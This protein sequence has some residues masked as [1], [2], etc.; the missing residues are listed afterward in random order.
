VARD[1]YSEWLGIEGGPRPPDHYALLGI[2]RFCD[3]P[4]LIDTVA[5]QRLDL[6]DKYSLAGSREN[7][8]ACQEIMNEV[9]RARV[10]LM[11]AERRSLYNLQLG[12]QADSEEPRHADTQA[13]SPE[14][15]DFY[16]EIVWAH[17]RKWR[18]DVHEER[19]L[20]AEAAALGI[21]DHIALTIARRI[22]SQAEDLAHTKQMRTAFGAIFVACGILV[23]VVMV[24]VFPP[25]EDR[26]PSEGTEASSWSS[27]RPNARGFIATDHDNDKTSRFA[28]ENKA[29][30]RHEQACCDSE[31]SDAHAAGCRGSQ[32]R[33]NKQTQTNPKATESCSKSHSA[34]G[35]RDMAFQFGRGREATDANFDR[36]G[37][38][39]CGDAVSRQE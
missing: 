38:K 33:P 26:Q 21:S 22:N 1:L 31:H 6:L 30:C 19:L 18:M 24:Y 23:A 32:A 20:I 11:N 35:I 27:G 7:R 37:R 16:K 28:T 17:L 10:V 36:A 3:D 4:D 14:A 29:C 34:Q 8:N 9:A 39:T 5:H 13:P 2:E 12:G 15:L 25:Q